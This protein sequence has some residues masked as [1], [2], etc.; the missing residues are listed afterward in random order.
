LKKK[1]IGQSYYYKLKDLISLNGKEVGADDFF[2]VLVYVILL[3][4]PR[5]LLSTVQ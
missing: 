3:A 4:N 1:L 5:N 2:P